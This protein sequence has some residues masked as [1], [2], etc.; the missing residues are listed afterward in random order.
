MKINLQFV[1][2]GRS[3]DA[4]ASEVFTFTFTPTVVRPNKRSLA[5]ADYYECEPQDTKQR[6]V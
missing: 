5:Y 2:D 6:N 3:K 1:T 4:Q